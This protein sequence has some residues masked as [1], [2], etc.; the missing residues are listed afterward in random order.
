MAAFE[1]N[2]ARPYDKPTSWPTKQVAHL[3]LE[4]GMLLVYICGTLFA[5]G[6]DVGNDWA[7]VHPVLLSKGEMHPV[8]VNSWLVTYSATCG[9]TTCTASCHVLCPVHIA[10]VCNYCDRDCGARIGQAMLLGDCQ[11]QPRE[12]YCTLL[13][14][15]QLSPFSWPKP[16]H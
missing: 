10:S 11:S 14:V 6:F 9:S 2:R 3:S 12:S 13:G 15:P 4:T 16:A 7:F 8:P 1:F 5:C